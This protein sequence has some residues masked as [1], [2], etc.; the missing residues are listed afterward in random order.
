MALLLLNL[1]SKS[2]LSTCQ[3][4]KLISKADLKQKGLYFYLNFLLLKSFGQYFKK[5]KNGFS[6]YFQK[7]IYLGR[8]LFL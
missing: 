6:L 4:Q 8:V 7:V 3:S 2:I 1:L 5:S